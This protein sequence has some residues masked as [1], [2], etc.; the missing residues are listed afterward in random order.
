MN[1]LYFRGYGYFDTDAE[2]Y[3]AALDAFLE[4]A[5]DAGID[6]S[7]SESGLYDLDWNEIE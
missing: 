6:I 3:D 5:A 7:I 1:Q 2:N 4:A